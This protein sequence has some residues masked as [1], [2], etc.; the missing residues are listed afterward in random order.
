MI[1]KKAK[2]LNILPKI[3][4]LEPEP[5]CE[6][7]DNPYPHPP[8]I[9]QPRQAREESED[10]HPWSLNPLEQQAE[11]LQLIIMQTKM[12]SSLKTSSNS[13]G[14][15]TASTFNYRN[16]RKQ[17]REGNNLNQKVGQQ[18]RHKKKPVFGSC[19]IFLLR[20]F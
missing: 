4:P 16:T 9:L 7:S 2:K 8:W 11:Y 5:G 17:R 1:R 20:G 15:L 13:Q 12:S 14:W 18:I 3:T 6:S 10:G 19:H